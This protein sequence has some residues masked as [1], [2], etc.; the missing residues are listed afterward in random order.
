MIIEAGATT[1]TQDNLNTTS[2]AATVATTSTLNNTFY[3]DLL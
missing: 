1:L 2:T 3:H